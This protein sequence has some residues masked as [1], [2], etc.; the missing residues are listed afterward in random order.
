MEFP[1]TDRASNLAHFF[2]VYILH[3]NRIRRILFYFYRRTPPFGGLHVNAIDVYCI[4]VSLCDIV[5]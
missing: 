4:T 1:K 3:S 2:C 5:L